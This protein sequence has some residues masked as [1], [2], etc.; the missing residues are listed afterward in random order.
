MVPV[1]GTRTWDMENKVTREKFPVLDT[2]LLQSHFQHNV[3]DI[4][5]LLQKYC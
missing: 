2:M 3:H 4:F 1:P 5:G